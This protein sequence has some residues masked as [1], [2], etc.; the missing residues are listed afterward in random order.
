MKDIVEEMLRHDAPSDFL[1][2][3]IEEIIVPEGMDQITISIGPYEVTVKI[4][5]ICRTVFINRRPTITYF[6]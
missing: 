4:L 1:L 2:K 3:A 6:L 5:E